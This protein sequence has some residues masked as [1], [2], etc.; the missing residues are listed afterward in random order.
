MATED[1]YIHWWI[2][3]V[4][5]AAKGKVAVMTV[6]LVTLWAGVMRTKTV[7]FK[8]MI[9]TAEAWAFK[10]VIC[11]SRVMKNMT[12]FPIGL[13]E[14]LLTILILQMLHQPQKSHHPQQQRMQV[15][16]WYVIEKSWKILYI[17]RHVVKYN[18]I[19]FSIFRWIKLLF[20]QAMPWR[21]KNHEGKRM[22]I[23]LQRAWNSLVR[24]KVQKWQTL[25]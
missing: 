8:T 3:V 19:F 16:I 12:N 17:K 23:S 2:R 4:S 9:P 25:L 5:T 13:V 6:Y 14:Y 10:L 22:Q 11:Y 20:A 7:I 24:Q 18:K 21:I 15:D 1:V